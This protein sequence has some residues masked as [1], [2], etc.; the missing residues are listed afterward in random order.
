MTAEAL[1]AI[2]CRAVAHAVGAHMA[3]A[4]VRGVP[5][6][7]SRRA[8]YAFRTPSAA[9]APWIY[10]KVYPDVGAASQQ[11]RL[12]RLREALA[13][14]G[15]SGG[16]RVPAPL[17]IDPAGRCLVQAAAAGRLLAD[18]PP[19][20]GLWVALARVGAALAQLHALPADL[21]G[22][23]PAGAAALAEQVRAL[24]R[25]QPDGLVARRPATAARVRA[26]LAGIAAALPQPHPLALAHRD[27]HPR[28]LF[29]SA[30]AVELIDWDLAGAADPALDLANLL[31]HLERHWRGVDAPARA[32]LLQGYGLE[33][34]AAL[35][36][37]LPAWQAFHHLRRACKAERLGQGGAA[38]DAALDLAACALATSFRSIE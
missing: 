4:E 9:D 35:G 32:A 17:G 15:R 16:L 30:E 23:P 31:L 3:G 5:S 14:E 10:A 38:V 29:V 7:A 6:A 34:V 28:Q 36:A 20:P 25:P 19:G 8:V 2:A 26:V 22:P 12:Q 33:R 27:V 24:M 37:R 13:H 11:L 18:T 21:L 1:Q